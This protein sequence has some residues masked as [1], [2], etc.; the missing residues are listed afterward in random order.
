MGQD[1]DWNMIGWIVPPPAFPVHVRPGTTNGSEHIPPK[2]PRPDILKA[3]GGE[4]IVKPGRAAFLAKQG[5]LERA[6][7]SQPL[8]QIPCA[9]TEW[10]V[11]ALI[12]ACA[13]SVK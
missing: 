10:V 5:A 12:R 11:E 4:I 7:L 2:N 1:K 3:A 8:V 13:V 9:N 6:C